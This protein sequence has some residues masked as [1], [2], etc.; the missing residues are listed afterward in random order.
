MELQDYLRVIRTYWWALVA[1]VVIGGLLAYGYTALQ[2]RVYT[3]S[4][5]AIITTGTSEDL[6][7]ALSGDSYARSRVV[8]YL[9]IAKSR[10]V[11][12]K[13]IEELGL[14]DS[15]D[16]LIAR[17]RV[18]N[19]I[20]TAVIRVAADAS[21]PEAARQLAEAWIGGMTDAVEDLETNSGGQSI[22]KLQT[23]DSALLPTAPSSPNTQLNVALGILL[24]G[25]AGLAFSLI[26]A[27]LDRRIRTAASVEQNFDLPVLGTIPHDPVIAKRGIIAQDRDFHTAEAIRQLRTNLQFMDIDN[28]PRMIVITSPEA[29]EGKSTMAVA[30]AE[31]IAESGHKVVLI[32][33][34]L[35]RPSLIDYL[36]LVA[37][38]GLTDVLVGRIA[39]EAAF[40]AWGST[41]RMAVMGAGSI[42]PNPSELL[43]SD[44]MR[45]LLERID[46][47]ATILLDSPPLLP[48]TD[49]AILTARTDGALVV[50]RAG[51]TT[52]DRL[53]QALVN[54]ER[55][56]GRALGVIIDGVSR[57]SDAARYSSKYKYE[58]SSSRR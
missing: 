38:A 49:A 43:G 53:D 30:L 25:A 42:P 41:G 12:T 14:N 23:L 7:D 11:A 36:G 22:V 47:T 32:D 2:P 27:A 6:N 34:D 19:P 33:A 45:Q 21:T 5:S 1:A 3:A 16:S 39:P 51:R 29:G 9:D 46:P 50:A 4:G 28:P 56:K 24:G 15:P 37:G 44:T 10:Q 20:D 58:S 17:V 35:R 55:V 8:S 52:I 48:V 31:A 54:L 40:Q 57:R 18:S 13:V 26:R